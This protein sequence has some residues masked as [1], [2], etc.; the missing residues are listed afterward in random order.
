MGVTTVS[1]LLSPIS[2]S[3]RVPFGGHL[4][5]LCHDLGAR[6]G[7]SGGPRLTCVAADEALPTGAGTML[8][9]IVDLL[10]TDAFAHAF[11][12]GRGG[13]IAV[14]FTAD[15]EAWQLTVDDSGIAIRSQGNSRDNGLTIARQLVLRIGGRLDIPRVIGG[16]RCIVSL[17]RPEP[18]G[19]D[20]GISPPP[21]LSRPER[22]VRKVKPCPSAELAVSIVDPG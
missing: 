11:P 18:K 12:P 2:G 21:R 14:S 4:R 1:A 8:A 9:L 15:Q 3:T 22:R 7:R 20:S 19:I 16:T 5:D 10:V 6:L 13:R 17:P